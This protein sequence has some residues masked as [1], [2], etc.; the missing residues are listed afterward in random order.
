MSARFPLYAKILGWFF[1][2]LLVLVVIFLLLVNAQFRFDLGWA[3]TTAARQR[4]NAM[5]DLIVG[6]LNTTRPDEWDRVVE[7]FG[8]AY[9]VRLALLDENGNRLIG[10]VDPLPPEV[11]SRIVQS[12]AERNQGIEGFLRTTNPARY[13]LL[14][15]A[16]PDNPEMAGPMNVLLVAESN[17]VTV[18]GLVMDLRMGALLALGSAIFSII[19][20]L[21]LLRGITRSIRQMT[22]ATERISKGQFD[23]RVPARRHDELGVL[24]E[25]IN[26]MGLRLDGLLKGQTRFL[27]DVAHELCSP[28][29]RLQ[30]ALGIIEQRADDKQ[31]L[32]AALAIEKASQISQLVNELLAFSKASFGGPT[33]HIQ[34][35][36]VSAAIEEAIRHEKTENTRIEST[37]TDDLVVS[38]DPELLIRALSNLLRNAIRY[39]ADAGPI[40]IHAGRQEDTITISIADSGPGVPEAELQNIFDAFYR[41]DASRNR[42]TGGSGLGLAIVRT[43]IDSC[44]GS[45]TADNRYPH[46]L[47]VQVH[48]PAAS[49]PTP[50]PAAEPDR[51]PEPGAAVN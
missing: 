9:N 36:P 38:A 49:I 5:R 11:R 13:W 25:A 33:L 24:A 35:V 28:L 2:N 16:Q 26:R 34:P 31:K 21:P 12:A 46:G 20:W 43:C 42:Q 18:G 32:Y 8:D 44:N 37:F 22:E 3:F 17:S 1:L 27:G 50:I 10:A 40:Q 39:G 48:L 23:V 19:L 4:V 47:A 14:V 6:E 41:V 51:I 30:M 45:V 7:S 29:S 15:S